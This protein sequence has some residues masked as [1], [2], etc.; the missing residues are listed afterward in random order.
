M[1]KLHQTLLLACACLFFCT[2]LYAQSV[3]L[4][5]SGDN[6]K[7]I[8]TQYIGSLAHVSIQYNSPD[9][10]GS[11]G[12]SR[13][14]QIWGQ[15]VPYGLTNLGFGSAQASPWRAGANENTVITFSHDMEVE[16]KPIRAG[17]YGLHMIVEEN[18]PWVMILSKN[19]SAWGSYF[20]DEKEDALRVE[21]QPQENE[22]REWLTYEFTDRQ[23]E[24]TVAALMWE[25]LKIP[26][27]IRVPNMN[28]LYVNNM[29]KELQSAAGFTWQ[30]WNQ[31]ATY[32]LQNDTHLEEAL[33]WA[34]NAIS[35]PYIGQE[36]FT[37][38]QT[39]ASILHKLNR[40]E[41]ATQLMA[42]A[43]E[44]PTANPLQIHAYG[45]QLI[46]QG[47]KAKAL[48]VFKHNAK[49][50]PDTW[51]VNVGLARG[52]SA[53]GDYKKALKYAKIAHEEAPDELNKNSLQAAIQSLEKG[54][55]I[56]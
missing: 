31:A 38:L 14:G 27:T 15:L 10:T 48:E 43:I 49:K 11:N 17:S 26:F 7:S 56:N 53:T 6:Q 16:G 18:Q 8:V 52:Y 37:T 35:M 30:G 45:R 32:C 29:R 39:K 33:S 47:E 21:L 19:S 25:N 1:K 22:Y 24:H 28:A 46:S 13:A 42:K 51:P 5:P 23:P 12:E 54:E 36:N 9:V 3:S 50:F 4:P 40:V 55:D 44:H 20:Y 34:D 2:R 41:E